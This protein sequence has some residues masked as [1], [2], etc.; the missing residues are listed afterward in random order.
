M[1]FDAVPD[2]LL[3]PV[4]STSIE[5][6]TPERARLLRLRNFL[7]KLPEDN[8]S[9]RTWAAEDDD[10][11]RHLLDPFTDTFRHGCGTACCIGGWA[12]ILF[13]KFDDQADDYEI[14]AGALIGLDRFQS[15][16]MFMMY[17]TAYNYH[18]VEL[19]DAV[20]VLDHYI[21]TGVIDWTGVLV[22]R[23]LKLR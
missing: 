2:P 14:V 17:G 21:A 6:P 5:A 23:F 3:H 10:L 18:H 15:R 1:A 7:A 13:G 4:A 12:E 16:Q 20:A 11:A 19:A 9:M 22:R 8:F